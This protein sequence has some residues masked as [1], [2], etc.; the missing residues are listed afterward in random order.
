[1]LN[2]KSL[3]INEVSWQILL[4]AFYAKLHTS[5]LYTVVSRTVNSTFLG[6]NWSRHKSIIRIVVGLDH[7]ATFKA[8]L[9]NDPDQHQF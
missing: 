5:A 6:G 2:I 1:M 8:V 9:P 4:P 3:H 7:L